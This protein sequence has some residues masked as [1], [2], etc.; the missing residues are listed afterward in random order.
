MEHATDWKPSGQPPVCSST[1]V[2]SLPW[3]SITGTGVYWSL[4]NPV[5]IPEKPGMRSVLSLSSSTDL[6][7]W[8][9]HGDIL[10]DDS[11]WAV[12]YTGFQYV[13]WLFDGPDML[14]AVRMG[15]NGSHNFH[16]AN[17]LTFHR[18]RDY[19]KGVSPVKEAAP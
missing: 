12:Q 4:V 1:Q 7:N 10:R 6:V 14:A 19:E 5:T 3:C 9:L 11:P 16:D 18:I 2:H 17:Y 15:F 13:D 8:T